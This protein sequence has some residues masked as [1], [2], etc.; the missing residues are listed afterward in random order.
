M[1]CCQF[2]FYWIRR[3]FHENQKRKQRRT[4]C[5][6]ISLIESQSQDDIDGIYPNSSSTHTK[7]FQRTLTNR[8]VTFWAY[9]ELILMVCVLF[10]KS[11]EDYPD[12]FLNGL[13]QHGK[14]ERYINKMI[15]TKILSSLMLAFGAKF[16]SRTK[17]KKTNHYKINKLN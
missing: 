4:E 7:H 13:C 3:E 8:L 9:A 6:R 2:L 1:V 5:H 10:A 14:C 12:N 11:N 16:V 17:E 15:C